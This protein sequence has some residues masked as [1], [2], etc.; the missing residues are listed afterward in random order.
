MYDIT[1]NYAPYGDNSYFPVEEG[2]YPFAGNNIRVYNDIVDTNWIPC[3]TT[4]SGTSK[5]TNDIMDFNKPYW[6]LGNWNSSYLRDVRNSNG[7]PE[8]RLFGNYFV[9][10]FDLG[11]QANLIE[12]ENLE[13][14]M[15]EDKK[16]L[17]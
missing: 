4:S 13:V 1:E 16:P 17:M 2:L 5:P 15:T 10:S 9:I 11:S 12:F 14:V 3:D 6:D 7:N 8:S